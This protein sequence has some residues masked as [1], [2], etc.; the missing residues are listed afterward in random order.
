MKSNLESVLWG[1]ET[2]GKNT[3]NFGEQSCDKLCIWNDFLGLWLSV[4]LHMLSLSEKMDSSQQRERESCP[5]NLAH[6]VLVQSVSRI[7]Q[8][9]HWCWQEKSCTTTSCL[10]WAAFLYYVW[11]TKAHYGW[12]EWEI[13]NFPLQF[14]VRISL[15]L[16]FGARI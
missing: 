15:N 2:L 11:Q 6:R 3:L 12:S 13:T 8:R 1:V 16:N 9:P 10:N 5:Q 7:K 4:G 14:I